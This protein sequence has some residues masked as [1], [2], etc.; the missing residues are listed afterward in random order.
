MRISSANEAAMVITPKPP[1][2]IMISI[3]ACPKLDQYVAVSCTI[4]P[5]THTADVEV[6]SVWLNGVTFPLLEDMGSMSISAPSRITP[7]NPNMI[8]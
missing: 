3:T 2:W 7:M 6:N 4:S 8:I 5:V 1:I